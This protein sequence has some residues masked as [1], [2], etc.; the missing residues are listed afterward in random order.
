M[1]C[2]TTTTAYPTQRAA[3]PSTSSHH[4]AP[5]RKSFGPALTHAT[6][7]HALPRRAGTA[8]YAATGA[9]EY[10]TPVS[11]A[12]AGEIA[13]AF[14]A[15]TV[16]VPVDEVVVM[17]SHRSEHTGVSHVYL[18]QVKGGVE[19]ANADAN[20]NIDRLGRVISY[21][22]A[23]FRGSVPAAPAA[24]AVAETAPALQLHQAGNGA[25]HASKP[26]VD[27][28]TAGIKIDPVAGYH[29]LLREL[30]MHD[31]VAQTSATSFRLEPSTSTASA[32]GK[33]K[34]FRGTIARPAYAES[35][36]TVSM[37]YLQTSSTS[38]K[39]VYEYEV[40]L[41]NNWYHAHVCAAT[42]AVESLV[43]WVADAASYEVYPIGVNDPDDGNRVRVK[44]PELVRASPDGW[45]S[46][47]TTIG[48]NVIAQENLSGKAD[49]L[50][51]EGELSAA[52]RPRSGHKLHFHYAI[53]F[54][55]NP[56]S[57]LDASIT[58]LFYTNNALHDLF[59]AY[60]FTE[61][62]GNFQADNFGRGGVA[63]DPVVAFAQDGSGYNNANFATPPDGKNGKMRMYVWNTV[64]PNRDGDLENG[65]VI[66]EFG[67]GVSNRLTG[68]PH[69]S[70]CLA[71][72]E[73]GGMGEGWGDV[74]ATIFRHRSADRARRDYGA[75]H[76][77]KYA[78]GGTTGI[79]KYPYSPDLDVNPS[80]YSFLNHAGYW[81]VH[82]KGEVWAAILLEVYWN[83]ID[84][85]GWTGDWKSAAVDKG[86][87]LFNQ[88]VVDG[89]TMQPCRPTFLDARS[90]ILQAEAVLTGGKHVCAIWRGF[91]K[92]G[93]GVDA[94]RI[95][96]K[97]PWD[98][99]TRIDG[100]SVPDECRS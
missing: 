7:R 4:H 15:A 35:D 83:L 61:N 60:G 92:R 26:T 51:Q 57:Y 75:W 13:A 22:E 56:K 67:H 33:H 12:P 19:V 64:V 27:A 65:I 68:G 3:V 96:G 38:A 62:A 37:T 58:Q 77:G 42:G 95:P 85:L 78:N 84:E 55:K 81:G 59:Y 93:L 25:Q 71:W 8:S 98:D 91:A 11:G 36:V 90:A 48:N 18:R 17:A 100:F 72:G 9:L 82:A 44:R 43:D 1:T 41:R 29:A 50:L 20:V 97:N 47:R 40:E 70:G 89:L 99:D 53:D 6:Y 54:A 16:G 34:L 23:F 52:Y 45:H 32:S 69:N 49:A 30:G 21:G 28:A 2:T 94:Q 88:L 5:S 31:A 63:G 73:S 86:N 14:V 10:L 79:R 74:W 80:T 76:M 24:A 87:T 66:H 46:D 39:L